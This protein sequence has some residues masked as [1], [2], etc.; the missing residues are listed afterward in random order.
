[1]GWRARA[2]LPGTLSLQ[3]IF[4]A[5][6]IRFLQNRPLGLDPALDGRPR[7]DALLR[8]LDWRESFVA[9]PIQWWS[10]DGSPKPGR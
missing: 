3:D 4:L 2:F 8:R 5:C 9:N 1:L 10:P 6:L 7:I